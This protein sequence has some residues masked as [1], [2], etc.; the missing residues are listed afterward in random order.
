MKVRCSRCP[1]ALFP[2]PILVGMS[3]VNLIRGRLKNGIWSLSLRVTDTWLLIRN[4]VGSSAPNLKRATELK[5]VLP[6]IPC[7]EP[8]TVRHWLP[9]FVTLRVLYVTI[10]CSLAL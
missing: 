4:S 1:T 9:I 7:A 2:N 5:H 10:L 6:C 8:K 3:V